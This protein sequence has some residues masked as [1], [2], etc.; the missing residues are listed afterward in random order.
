MCSACA[1]EDLTCICKAFDLNGVAKGV[2][3]EHGPLFTNLSSKA[4]VRLN[5]EC[6]AL[7]LQTLGE[8]VPI[9]KTQNQAKMWH[10]YPNVPHQAGQA[11]CKRLTQMQ[12]KLMAIKI[13]VHPSGRGSALGAAELLGIK[14]AGHR[15]VCDVKGVVKKSLHGGGKGAK[16]NG[17]RNDVDERC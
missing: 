13:K 6:Q 2:A 14:V 4:T 15:Q 9:L 16:V 7:S 3:K 5:D 12:R 11:C 10:R 17:G 8:C 1:L